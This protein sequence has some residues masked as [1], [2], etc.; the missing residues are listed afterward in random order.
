MKKF[1]YLFLLWFISLASFAQSADEE[2][3]KFINAN[4]FFSLNEK[5]A[6]AKDEMQSSM[7]KSLT[8]AILNAVFNRPQQA[9]ES[10]DLLVANYQDEI[11]FDNVKN[12]LQWQ[13]NIL[14]RMGEYCKA[15]ERANSFLEQV[16]PHLDASTISRIKETCKYYNSMCGQKKS[17]L[18]R[19]D[20]D[21]VIPI[22]IEP[23][24]KKSFEKG[25]TLYVPVTVNGTEEKFIF[26]TGCPGGAFL[27]EEYAKKLG[28]KITMDSL[29]VSGY[30]GTGWG[31]MGILNSLN[32][33][34][35]IF[36]NLTVTIVPPNPAVDAVFKID[37]VL[38]S[39][40]MKLAGEVQI[41]PKEKK[42]I[43]PVSKTPIPATGSNLL[44]DRD[45]LFSLKTY[46][47][48]ERLI[49]LFDTGGSSSGLNYS[50]YQRHKDLMEKDSKKESS[51][52]GGFGGIKT[53]YYYNL[54]AFPL[55]I[56]NKSII[57]KNI[58]V[59]AEA[60]DIL[61]NREGALGMSFINLFD[62]VTINFDQM[63]VKVE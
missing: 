33:G 55:N 46:S 38:G 52:S 14:F 44:L 18:I 41:L 20:K 36:K 6:E 34:N 61:L 45:D 13:N 56:G 48:N 53:S 23:F 42:M 10:I 43:F 31:K 1:L 63:F 24:E 26:D 39:D 35:M 25:H 49:M 17:E 16:E 57:M 22:F 47:N 40:I 2:I 59:S 15:S 27:S 19:P 58:R 7:L 9:V 30:G 60:I 62:K 8:E 5:Y 37:A 50:Y 28:V 4:D 54:P 3:G 12:M 32:I 11:G 51:L 29:K 21:C